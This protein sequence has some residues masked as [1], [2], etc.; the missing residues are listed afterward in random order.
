MPVDRITLREIPDGDQGTRVTLR[1][2]GKLAKDYRLH[3]SIYTKARALIAHLPQKDWTGQVRVLTEYVRDCIRYVH[4][5]AG[6]EG[7]QTPDITLELAAGDCDDK[8]TLLAALLLSI[9]HPVQFAAAKIDQAPEYGHVFLRTLIG[10]GWI[11]LETTEPVPVGT[12][13][14]NA[15]RIRQPLLIFTV[16]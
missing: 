1:L 4:D 7:I 3:P 16:R 5:P 14:P 2:M 9:S 12:L 11:D 8:C 13:G 15:S 6:A 10:A